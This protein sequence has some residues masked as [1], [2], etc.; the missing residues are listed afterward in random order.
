MSNLI[1]L[2]LNFPMEGM[3][4]EFIKF[5]QFADLS[6]IFEESASWCDLGVR[7]NDDD[8]ELYFSTNEIEDEEHKNVM[9][10]SFCGKSL[11]EY[12]D[13][14]NE[15]CENFVEPQGYYNEYGEDCCSSCG[16]PFD[17]IEG[18]YNEDCDDYIEKSEED[19]ST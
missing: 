19:F 9:I 10:C 12:G 13:C 5:L 3:R 15:E 18:C 8:T 16:T 2:K 6:E 7:C 17:G 14:W 1:I 11:N 4:E